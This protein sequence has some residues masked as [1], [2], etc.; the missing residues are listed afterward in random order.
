[1]DELSQ[2][3]NNYLVKKGTPFYWNRSS[4]G[5]P[6]ISAA[7]FFK[8]ACFPTEMIF[9]K[10]GVII[11]CICPIRIQLDKIT[12]V[13][14]LTDRLND[15]WAAGKYRM[16]SRSQMVHCDLSIS[17]NEWEGD[18][19][20]ADTIMEFTAHMVTRLFQGI[21]HILYKDLTPEEAVASVNLDEVAK[22]KNNLPIPGPP[23]ITPIL[24]LHKMQ[25]ELN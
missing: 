8:A 10:E 22:I 4:K 20:A 12:D 14:E 3:I 13:N 25:V 19:E 21:T 16:D 7:I 5:C 23:K 24:N 15:G 6:R 2:K 1:M 18:D 11:R 9:S 17:G